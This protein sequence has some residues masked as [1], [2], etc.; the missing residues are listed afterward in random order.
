MTRTIVV[1]EIIYHS[2]LLTQYQ[3]NKACVEQP[4]GRVEKSVDLK[5]F[6]LEVR[7]A[8][9]LVNS[10]VC[11]PSSLDRLHNNRQEESA[12]P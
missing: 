7:G 11:Q 10:S 2:S 4:G 5:G 9:G 12:H 1:E 6:N 3:P 8:V